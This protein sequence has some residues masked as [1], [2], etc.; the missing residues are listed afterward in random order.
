MNG[1]NELASSPQRRNRIWRGTRRGP[2][3]LALRMPRSWEQIAVL[4]GG[5]MLLAAPASAEGPA[6]WVAGLTPVVGIMAL[7]AAVAC[8]CHF[9][10]GAEYR[11]LFFVGLAARVAVLAV[12]YILAPAAGSAPEVGIQT[13]TVFV[14]GDDVHY[15]GAAE[16]LVGSKVGVFGATP[17]GLPANDKVVRVA[18]LLVAVK[19]VFGLE[20]VWVRLVGTII[21]ALT[22]VF[23]VRGLQGLLRPQTE[24]WMVGLVCFGPEFLGSSIF[25]YKEGYA[26]FAGALALL[27]CRGLIDRRNAGLRPFLVL[28][29]ATVVMYWCRRE[30]FLL[31]IA[32]GLGCYAFPKIG[33][34]SWFG[35]AV[36]AAVALGIGLWLKGD[37]LEVGERIEAQVEEAGTFAEAKAFGWAADLKGVARIVHIPIA[38]INP[39][40]FNLKCYVIPNP[41]NDDWFRSCFRELRTLQWWVMLPWVLIGVQRLARGSLSAVG[42]LT[43]WFI[44]V[45]VLTAFLYNGNHPEAVR[46]RGTFLAMGVLLAGYGYDLQHTAGRR[47]FVWGVYGLGLAMALAM[48]LRG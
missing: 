30:F 23:A 46:Y 21:G 4:A 6:S 41:G 42:V 24:R 36:V 11:R 25:L 14:W 3:R 20:Q 32:A 27:A 43:M 40:T 13:P 45:L 9:A 8:F 29:L 15:A 16:E 34:G 12:L 48:A 47:Y 35:A 44:L 1:A 7:A 39:P 10:L 31:V 38:F 33:R 26:I 17:V 19:L 5:V 2:A 37:D 28:L 18:R 22:V